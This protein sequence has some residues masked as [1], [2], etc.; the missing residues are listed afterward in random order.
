MTAPALNQLLQESP[1][2]DMQDHADQV[3]SIMPVVATLHLG[4]RI[5]P[6]HANFASHNRTWR[7]KF[8]ASTAPIQALIGLIGQAKGPGGFQR[9]IMA[10]DVGEIAETAGQAMP[11]LIGCVDEIADLLFEYDPAL[12]ADSAWILD[13]ETDEAILTAFITILQVVYPVKKLGATVAANG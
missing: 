7:Q 13:H 3:R 10:M 6:I 9:A 1:A 4:G 11:A 5:Y 12:T 8:K 2:I